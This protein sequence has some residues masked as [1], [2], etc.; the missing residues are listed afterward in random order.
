[1]ET[2]L[3]NRPWR[4]GM[5]LFTSSVCWIRWAILS[6]VALTLLA[7]LRFPEAEIGGWWSLTVN[8]LMWFVAVTAGI[9]LHANLALNLSR[10]VTRREY[11]L[12]Y[13][14]FGLLTTAAMTVLA[15]AGFLGEH[16]VL[17]AV[18]APV[19]TWGG[20]LAAGLR[21]LVV[22]PIYF[23]AGAAIAALGTRFGSNPAAFSAVVIVPAGAIYAGALSIEFFELSID[24]ASWS[25]VAWAGGS[26]ALI[27]AMVATYAMTL[28]TIPIRS[29]AS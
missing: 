15:T 13:A 28:R 4:L 7:D 18:A 9:R 8:I 21:Y 5:H 12:A 20:S 16:A 11:I 24:S 17:S 2:R 29:R 27:V 6:G 3:R 10:G 23:F 26:A 19:E 14:A 1:M 22:T 25:F